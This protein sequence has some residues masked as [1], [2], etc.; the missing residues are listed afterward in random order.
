MPVIKKY[1]IKKLRVA[2]IDNS[3]VYR[4]GLIQLLKSKNKVEV[5][6]ESENSSSLIKKIRHDTPDVIL[7]DFFQLGKFRSSIAADLRKIYPQLRIIGLAY[8]YSSTLERQLKRNGFNGYI[9]KDE[10]IT[11]VNK[12]IS[13]TISNGYFDRKKPFTSITELEIIR[14]EISDQKCSS[15]SKREIQI[16]ELLSKEYTSKEIGLELHISEAT[17]K[18]H[19]ENILVKTGTKNTAGL[20]MYAVRSKII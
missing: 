7:L 5:L 10:P 13:E 9:L 16:V 20:V 11:T 12:L 1:K 18:R 15:L 8:K 17:V 6:F 3:P 14:K 19:R 4:H 2:I